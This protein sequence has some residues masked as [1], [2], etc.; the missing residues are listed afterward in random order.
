MEIDDKIIK[1]KPQFDIDREAAQTSSEKIDKYE[2]LT[3]EE[4]LPL[5]QCRIIEK[6][7]LIYSLVG[8]VVQKQANTIEDQVETQ[9]KAIEGKVE[10]NLLDTDQK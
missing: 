2:Y 1:G 3:G 7:K 9:I 5:E 10:K 4:I 8:K 6:A